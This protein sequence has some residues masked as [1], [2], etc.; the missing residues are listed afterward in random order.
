MNPTVQ[1]LCSP[2]GHSSDMGQK[3]KNQ[4]NNRWM[5]LGFLLPTQAFLAP[6][7]PHL[8]ACDKATTPKA[9]APVVVPARIVAAKA[10]AAPMEATE[11]MD[12]E[13]W[14]AEWDMGYLDLLIFLLKVFLASVFVYSWLSLSGKTWKGIFGMVWDERKQVG[15][16]RLVKELRGGILYDEDFSMCIVPCVLSRIHI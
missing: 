4:T 6:L 7:Q 16:T 2:C 10:Q 12:V 1:W 9:A 11:V 15:L 14:D 8:L 5:G 13:E 3:E